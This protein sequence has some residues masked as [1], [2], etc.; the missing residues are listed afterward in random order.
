[1]QLLVLNFMLIRRIRKMFGQDYAENNFKNERRFLMVTMFFFSVG[2]LLISVRSLVGYIL[3]SDINE[4]WSLEH[5]C[6]HNYEVVLFNILSIFFVYILPFTAIFS[7]HF[8]NFKKEAKK[9]AMI[10]KVKQQYD[11]YEN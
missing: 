5:I 11:E 7:L 8:V 9:Q 2:Y 1:M 3:F 4:N 10:E 6:G